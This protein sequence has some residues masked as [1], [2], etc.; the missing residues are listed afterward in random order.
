MENTK[1]VNNT[2]D[3]QYCYEL[4][5]I[6]YW[7]TYGDEKE[8]IEATNNY[9]DR[10]ELDEAIIEFGIKT[11]ESHSLILSTVFVS[12]YTNKLY[13]TSEDYQAISNSLNNRV[14][15]FNEIREYYLEI[16]LDFCKL[17][18]INIK[19]INNNNDD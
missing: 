13:P 16:G 11:E 5:F 17:L 7:D 14:V 10:I 3:Y 8:I 18:P 12:Y 19:R 4:S 9:E 15:H 6:Q 2:R 1:T